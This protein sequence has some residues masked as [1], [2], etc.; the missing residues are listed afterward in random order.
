M[1]PMLGHNSKLNQAA[2]IR[3]S[4][5]GQVKELEWMQVTMK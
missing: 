2:V 4:F 3:Q 1:G 5:V